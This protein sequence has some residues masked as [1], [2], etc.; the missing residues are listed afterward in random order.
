MH[1]INIKGSSS[2]E[3]FE[4]GSHQLKQEPF[5]AGE[6]KQY[7]LEFDWSREHIT[8]DWSITAWAEKG[9]VSVKYQ[10]GRQSDT[11]PSMANTMPSHQGKT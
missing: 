1:T 3:T 9:G 6:K 5:K 4:V 7:V 2:A 10:D 11:L 8:P